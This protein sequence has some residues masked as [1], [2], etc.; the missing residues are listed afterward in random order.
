[1]I[2]DSGLLF[3]GPPCKLR[4]YADCQYSLVNVHVV[5]A[6]FWTNL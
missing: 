4:R 2:R 5:K 3:I 6:F 1:M